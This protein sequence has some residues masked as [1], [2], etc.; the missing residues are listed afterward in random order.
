MKKILFGLGILLVFVGLT[1]G[2]VAS[3][4]TLDQK[5]HTDNSSSD[6][7]SDNH[8]EHDHKHTNEEQREINDSG[9][10]SLFMGKIRSIFGR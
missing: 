5:D 8:T 4:E 7:H 1:S 6:N 2:Y 9:L 3:S 10:L